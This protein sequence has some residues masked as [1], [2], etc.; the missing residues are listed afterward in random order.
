MKKVINDII[1]YHDHNILNN[2]P[3]IKV[4]KTLCLIK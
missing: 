1:M 2:I 4:K 3:L